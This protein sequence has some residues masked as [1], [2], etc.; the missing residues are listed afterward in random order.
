MRNFSGHVR[1]VLGLA[2]IGSLVSGCRSADP[3]RVSPKTPL[4]IGAV[5]DSPPL[6]FRQAGGWSGVEADLG[7]ALAARLG[8][9]PVFVAMPP[10]KLASALLDGQVDMLMAGMAITEDL[11]V[12]MDFSTPYLVVGQAALVRTSDLLLYNTE[13]KIRSARAQIGVVAGSSGDR[14]VSRY[15]T[16]ATRTAYPNAKEAAAALRQNRIDLLIY[17]APAAW[18]L[19]THSE[20]TL[21]LAPALFAREEIAWA[22]RRGSVTLRD[23]ANMALADWRRDGSLESILQRWI[24]F[25]K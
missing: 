10:H 3:A 16:N 1:L 24:P 19:A 9:K 17:D 21:T 20:Q 23:S 4:R 13:I 15:F 12:Q 7:R 25:S 18:W 14:L 22:F 2:L 8:M 6:I 5:A 11:R